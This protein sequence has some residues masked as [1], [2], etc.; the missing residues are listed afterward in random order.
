MKQ[1]LAEIKML[2]LRIEGMKGKEN[3][4]QISLQSRQ[5]K[6]EIKDLFALAFLI[7][8]TYIYI[9]ILEVFFWMK[10]R[11]KVHLNHKISHLNSYKII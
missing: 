7:L 8:K 2:L 10:L 1:L 4:L 5:K 11:Y 3:F 9:I 6:R